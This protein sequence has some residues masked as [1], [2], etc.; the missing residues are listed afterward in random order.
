MKQ[1]IALLL[2]ALLVPTFSFAQDNK[3]NSKEKDEYYKN[4]KYKSFEP[5][6]KDV[7]LNYKD[8]FFGFE[9]IENYT[10]YCDTL[11]YTPFQDSI[12]KHC[13]YYFWHDSIR[14]SIGG[15]DR[16]RILKYEKQDR[17]EAF[18]YEDSKYVRKFSA[19]P[20]LWVAYSSDGGETWAY[21]YTGIV[22][23][24]PIFVKWYSKLPLINDEGDLQIEACLL[25]Q[26]S[27][28]ILP[29]GSPG[30]NVQKDRLLLTLDLET[31]RKDSDG[32]GL[33]DIVEA[34]FRTDPN[35]A[36]TDGDGIPDNLDLNPRFALPRT[37][38]TVIM[39]TV[40]EDYLLNFHTDTLSNLQ[41]PEPN[42][43]TDTTE[44]VLIVSNSPDIQSIQPKSHRIIILTEEEYEFLKE[45]FDEDL[46][47]TT[48]T[49]L[50]KVDDIPN[51]FVFHIDYG[52][53]GKNY[54]VVRIDK[55]WVLKITSSMID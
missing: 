28:Y 2:I 53:S 17:R 10:P 3:Y 26:M 29:F 14:Q 55:G 4:R 38:K 22:Q 19:E 52:M 5:L 23:R 35:K 15:I 6:S 42:Y 12:E 39:E 32:D 47:K 54:V 21:Y 27:S 13:R 7:F 16:Y 34:R 20:E 1:Y 31:L 18:V 41:I 30:F 36:D 51:A 45:S 37:E 8:D 44:T 48:I 9:E 24:Q 50:F 25:R 43:A 46:P 11:F 33:T 40:I 49:P